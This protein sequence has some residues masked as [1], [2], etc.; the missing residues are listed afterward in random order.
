MKSFIRRRAL[1]L[2]IFSA[3]LAGLS[4][5]FAGQPVQAD[6]CPPNSTEVK[7]IQAN[8]EVV[9]SCQCIAGYTK[10]EGRCEEVGKVNKLK[11]A[12]A[13][14]DAIGEGRKPP[15]QPVW[16]YYQN[17]RDIAKGFAP[18]ENRCAIV[19][20]ITLGVEPRA[21]EASLRDLKLRGGVIP[22]LADAEIAKRYYIRA[23]ELANRLRHEWGEPVVLKSSA[24]EKAITGKRGIVFIEDGWANARGEMT[25]DHIDVWNGRL[26]GAHDVLEPHFERSVRV[27]FWELP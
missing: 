1:L 13:I 7:R 2:F 5:V 21:N 4:L 22:E 18:Q 19:L 17:N 12:K 6:G 16:D 14:K 15:F 24:A 26:I 8:G 10:F 11:N 3:L 9:V 23:Q 20:S 27:L 25:V